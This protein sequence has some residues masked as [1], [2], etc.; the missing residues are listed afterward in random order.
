MSGGPQTEIPCLS[1]DALR[2][3]GREPATPFQVRGED[4][5][6]IVVSR[7]L[8]V[9]PGKRLVGEAEWCGWRGRRVLAKLFVGR[10]GDRRW[11]RERQGL[12]LLRDAG[13]PT[14]EV[15][16][17]GRIEGGG[18]FLLTE[19][20]EASRT[21][22]ERC[23]GSETET[24]AP[25]D[26]PAL[27]ALRPA[28][29]L[30]GRLHAA[31]LI[32]TDPHLGNFLEH[33]GALYLIDGDGVRRARAGD[34]ARARQALDNLALLAAQLPPAWESRVD[35]LLDAYAPEYTQEYTQEHALPNFECD[36]LARAIEQARARRL[37]H[38][39]GKTLRDCSQFAVR[40]TAR[41]F[42]SVVRA[43]SEALAALL[44]APD[45]AIARGALLKDGNT[46][47]VA[48][49]E[50]DGRALVVKRYNLKNPCH[51]LSRCWRPSRAWHAWLAAHRLAFHGVATPAPLAL[52]EERA[53]P[54]RR[55]AFLVT[56][57]CPGDELGQRLAPGREPDTAEAAAIGALF[58]LLFRLKI[59]H[60]DL[61]ATN[62]LWRGPRLVLLDLDAVTL[63]RSEA[64][65]ARGWRRDRARFL[66]NWPADSALHRWLDAH[67]P[68]VR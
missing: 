17:A 23:A 39:L 24:P 64:A 4:G 21:L 30:L 18:R 33:Q 38:F 1:S 7:L 3:G 12:A 47:T 42:S 13:L 8:R 10:D 14:P 36:V 29:A 68:E 40:R 48:R 62:F 19:F 2:R 56:E 9:L 50:V 20:L 16:R 63:H 22:A 52:V 45:A 49:V 5:E 11:A 61:K 26:A 55:R 34:G 58:G 27:E 46:C 6:I 54:L 37:A 65:F 43:E 31:G 59:T 25:E 41:R 60:G 57:F 53:G 32:Q 67:L 28:F 15:A 51:A 35:A 44:D 66:R